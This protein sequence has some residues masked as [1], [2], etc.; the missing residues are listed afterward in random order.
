MKEAMKELALY[1]S[2]VCVIGVLLAQ[3]LMLTH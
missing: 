1:A 2:T 3:F